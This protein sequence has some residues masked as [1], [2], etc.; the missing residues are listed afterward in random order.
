MA[1]Q[2]DKL[3]QPL[4]DFIQEQKVFFV[5]TA[6]EEG[7][8]NLSPKG[9][10]SLRIVDENRVVWLNLTGSGNETAAHLGHNDRIT[11]MFCAFEGDPMILRLYGTAKTH[12][13]ESTFW[14]DHI[15]LFP[16]IKGGRQLIDI[17]IE[18]VQISCGMGVPIMEY[19]RQRQGLLD[20]AEK[21]GDDG[22]KKYWKTRNSKSL[23]GH[24]I[25]S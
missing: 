20:W 4:I 21:Q 2:L 19:K 6:M 17:N 18:M 22:L 13:F 7:S 16:P 8:I 12:V 9:L 24:E 15:G 1:R 5:A 3:N 23:D 14:N 10:D 11:L 25:E